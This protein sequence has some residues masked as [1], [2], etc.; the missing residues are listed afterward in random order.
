MSYLEVFGALTGV[1]FNV[2]KFFGT[3][4]E[5][6]DSAHPCIAVRG[7]ESIF[8]RG[9]PIVDFSRGIQKDFS[10]GGQKW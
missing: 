10:M 6:C 8:S 3:E 1:E 9:G 7:V 2:S 5:K 4:S